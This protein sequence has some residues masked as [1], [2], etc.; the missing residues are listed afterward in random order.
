MQS[1]HPTPK[2]SAKSAEYA[3]VDCCIGSIGELVADFDRQA[4]DT[5]PRQ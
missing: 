3:P 1:A 2:R 4:R 5:I